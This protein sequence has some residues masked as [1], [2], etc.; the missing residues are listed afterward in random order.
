MSRPNKIWFRK[1]VGWWMVTLGG[2]KIRLAE[3]RGNK[4]AAEQKFHE[5]MALGA[6]AAEASDARVADILDAF[7]AW[8]KVH[9]SEETNR[10][11]VWYGQS[12]AEHSG[13]V[14]AVDV[15]PIHVTHWVDSHKWGQTTERNARRSINRAFTWSVEQGLLTN[16]PLQGMKCPPAAT[17]QRAMTEVEFRSML[18]G[19]KRDFKVLLFSLRMTGCRPKEARTLRWEQV[20]EDR[21]HLEQHKTAHSTHKPRVI[22][23]TPAMRKL[24]A[25][26]RRQSKSPYVFVNRRGEMWTRNAMRLR[27]ERLKK[28]KSLNLPEDLCCYLA[29]H[30]FGTSAIMNGVDAL[31]VAQLMGHASVTMIQKVY[32]HLA[33]EHAHLQDAVERATKPLASPKPRPAASH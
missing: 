10:N 24:M 7:L 29:R 20:F 18:R 3:G 12:F 6:R 5:L 1:D 31:S 4:K 28:N 13:Y 22:Y 9:R 11:L 14:K 2:R 30:A 32:V 33:G 8:S 26:L 23:L 21:W 19:S 16:N 17:R 27:V 25:V 15:R